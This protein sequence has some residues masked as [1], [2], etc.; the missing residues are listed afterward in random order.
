MFAYKHEVLDK[1]CFLYE[2]ILLSS[3]DYLWNEKNKSFNQ[4]QFENF[5]KNTAFMKNMNMKGVKSHPLEMF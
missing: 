2:S 3:I 5:K 1:Y 4:S